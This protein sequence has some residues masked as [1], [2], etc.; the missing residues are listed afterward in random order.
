MMMMMMMMTMKGCVKGAALNMGDFDRKC[1]IS[2]ASTHI[3][4]RVQASA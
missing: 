4:F 2:R 1:K 3:T